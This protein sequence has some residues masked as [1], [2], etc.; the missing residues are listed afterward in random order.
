MSKARDIA[1]LDFNS[2]DID[3][4]NIDG[5]TIGGTTPAAGTFTGMKVNG[6]FTVN[7]N[8]DTSSNLGEVLQLSQTDSAGG[9]LWSVD[10]ANNTY[11]HM[12]YHA[13]R[14]K[15]YSDASTEMM[16]I[17]SSGIDVTGEGTFSSTV[18]STV[19]SA[20]PKLKAAYN[21]SNYIGI[22]HEKINVQGGGVGLIIQGNGVDRATFASGGGLTLANGDLTLT[23]GKILFGTSY[24]GTIGT[25][26]GDLFIGTADANILFYNGS[27]VLPAN[28]AGG[29]RDNAIDLGSSSA[30]FK[31]LF[32][33]GNIALTTADNASAAN[34]FVSPSTDFLYLE[35]P[36]N[37]M[38]FRNTSGT[39]RLRIGA[40]GAATFTPSSGES[41]VIARDGAGPYFGNSSNNSLRIITNN[42]SRINISNSG[43]ISTHP[44]AGNHFVINDDGVNSDFRVES[45][46]DTHMLFVDGGTNHVGI[47]TSSPQHPLSIRHSDK[48]D[49]QIHLETASYGNAYGV[50]IHAASTNES[51][52]V[53]SFSSIHKTTASVNTRLNVQQH[54]SSVSNTATS[55]Y[56]YWS[57]GGSEQL[58]IS[59]GGSVSVAGNFYTNGNISIAAGNGILLGGTATANKLD[60]YEEGDFSLV[61]SG[62]TTAGTNSGGSIGGRYTKIGNLVTCHVVI[63][64]TTLSGASGVL[65]LTGFP[66][67]PANYANRPAIG[68]LRTYTF[69]LASPSNGYFSPTISLEHNVNYAHIVQTKDDGTW[70]LA[71]VENQ[72]GLY[73]EGTVSYTTT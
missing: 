70:S 13:S 18:T 7:G 40:N 20:N 54:I 47:G 71:P 1:D 17:T 3:G 45:D 30:R 42:A 41:V 24:N 33:S 22:S 51:G 9:F 64:N 14:H 16:S 23:S 8:V 31:D 27:S 10:R 59:G 6:S 69:D 53:S 28:S 62:V 49:P 5:A 56:Q 60:D 38:I 66:F 34:M 39:E 19:A 55:D 72:S 35:H 15:F 58:R 36:A 61:L 21:S 52:T 43:N 68:V 63:A 65:K 57:A 11:K 4:G 25:A 44:P 67:I 2:P 12:T 50:K 46:G 48:A 26:S 37:G 29:A 73:F 32:L